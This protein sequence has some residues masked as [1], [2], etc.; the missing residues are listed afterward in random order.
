MKRSSFTDAVMLIVC[1]LVGAFFSV[2]LED[3]FSQIIPIFFCMLIGLLGLE[4]HVDDGDMNEDDMFL[5]SLYVMG[6]SPLNFGNIFLTFLGK[7]V[8]FAVN[9]F[10]F[11]YMAYVAWNRE[12]KE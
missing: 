4:K 8:V 2:I 9:F 5:W 12:D 3:L 7:I 11:R 1:I 6:L 10:I